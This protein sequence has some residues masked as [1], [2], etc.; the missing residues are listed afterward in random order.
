[1]GLVRY[2]DKQQSV[3]KVI[4]VEDTLLLFPAA[5]S[6][7][8]IEVEQVTTKQLGRLKGLT[9]EQVVAIGWTLRDA[10][11]LPNSQ[12]EKLGEFSPGP[13]ERLLV[14]LNPSRNTRRDTIE[15]YRSRGCSDT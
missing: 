6:L 2:L 1:M 7:R 14:L 15:L 3:K 13:L 10:V 12:F 9:C 4:G 8:T 5:F 11:A